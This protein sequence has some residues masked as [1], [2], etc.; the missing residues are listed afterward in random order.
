MESHLQCHGKASHSLGFPSLVLGGGVLN[1][2]VALEL[3]ERVAVLHEHRP[4]VPRETLRRD[5]SHVQCLLLLQTHTHARTNTHTNTNKF[6][7]TCSPV[8]AMKH[9]SRRSL[10]KLGVGSRLFGQG[11]KLLCPKM[12]WCEK[13]RLQRKIRC[14]WY[15]IHCKTM[16]V[17]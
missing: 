13:K 4:I 10:R 7:R 15:D 11:Q 8:E 9:S 17:D 6:L 3:E 16:C 5:Y 14:W 1:L 2:S 12:V